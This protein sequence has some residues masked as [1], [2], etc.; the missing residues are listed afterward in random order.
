M[1]PDA[2]AERVRAADL[3]RYLATLYA[4][5]TL[6]PALYAL[7]ALDLELLDVARSTSEPMIGLIRLA[8]WRDALERLDAA[9]PP[10]QPLLEA[11]AER[12]LPLGVTG[13]ELSRLESGFAPL[14][15]TPL[16]VEAYLAGRGATL[17]TLAARLGDDNANAAGAGRLWAA[18]ELRRLRD[19]SALDGIELEADIRSTPAWLRGLADLAH[20]DLRAGK[21]GQ[22]GSPSRQ[23]RLLWS[24]IRPR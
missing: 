1:A 21:V 10:A 13:L 20:I 5:A 19:E 23:L 24:M 6:R 17:F 4:P 22:R 16:D 18:G 3:D 9:P 12:V 14:I 2:L 11:L 15:E 7:H 8:W